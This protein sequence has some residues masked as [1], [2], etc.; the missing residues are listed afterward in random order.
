MGL[1]C[2]RSVFSASPA[3][4]QGFV[5]SENVVSRHLNFSLL[6]S[7]LGLQFLISGIL[8]MTTM[9]FPSKTPLVSWHP[10][11]LLSKLGEGSRAA[12]CRGEW[13]GARVHLQDGRKHLRDS[14][15]T[16]PT[17]FDKEEGKLHMEP[18]PSQ[19]W[20]QAP[21]PPSRT[22]LASLLVVFLFAV[23][24]CLTENVLQFKRI[25]SSVVRKTWKWEQDT[26]CSHLSGSE[27]RETNAGAHLTPFQ[28][29]YLGTTPQPI[30]CCYPPYGCVF[31][32]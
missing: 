26:A 24:R 12:A 22:A 30:G 14:R 31:P 20:L 11:I 29:F 7:K 28:L 6:T 9:A 21:M 25:Q 5:S 18:L 8:A 27:N 3:S 19:E 1:L 16:Q 4:Q 10:E 13:L 23:T 32:A 15:C 2:P 17:R